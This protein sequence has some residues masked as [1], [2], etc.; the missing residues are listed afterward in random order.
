MEQ[1]RGGEEAKILNLQIST[2]FI[3]IYWFRALGVFVSGI[4]LAVPAL[5]LG[6][7]TDGRLKTDYSLLG[8][9]TRRNN[10]IL[11]S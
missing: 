9:K 7:L 11:H 8:H 2:Y 3:F 6:P 10:S 1:R 4:E 5:A